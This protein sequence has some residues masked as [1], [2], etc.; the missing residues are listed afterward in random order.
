MCDYCNK[1][2]PE[3]HKDTIT[4]ADG[5]IMDNKFHNDL[6]ECGWVDV[7]IIGKTLDLKYDAF[8]VDSSFDTEIKIKYC[9]MC[10]RR[11]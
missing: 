8:S 7:Q 1:I 11:L 5:Y 3:N 6:L 4:D 2:K 10:G 9:P